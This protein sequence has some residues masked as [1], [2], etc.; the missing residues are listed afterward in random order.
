MEQIK[1]KWPRWKGH[2]TDERINR[3]LAESV[4]LMKEQGVPISESICP[5]VKLTS[6]HSYYGC[7]FPKGSRKYCT[8]Y[9]Y[10]IEIS[11]FTLENTERSLRNTL[12]HELIHTVPGGL[13]HTG[14]WKKWAKF[15]SDKTGYN[16]QHYDGDETEEDKERLR[17]YGH[18]KL[19]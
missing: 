3:M 16:I 11:G 4:A 18:T 17:Y 8:E 15:V 10:Y 1:H 6:A 14:E 12:I 7:C 19:L 2:K 9:E 13:C 5:V